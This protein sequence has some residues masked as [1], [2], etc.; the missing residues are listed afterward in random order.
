VTGDVREINQE[1]ANL[2]S[3]W[4]EKAREAKKSV[5]CKGDPSRGERK[6]GRKKQRAVPKKRAKL[7]H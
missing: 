5:T 6:A 7:T 1:E 4:A 2:H 3:T